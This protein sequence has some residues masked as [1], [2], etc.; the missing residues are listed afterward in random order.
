MEDRVLKGRPLLGRKQSGLTNGPSVKPKEVPVTIGVADM[1]RAKEFYK[2]GIG[3]PVKKAFGNKFVMFGGDDGTSD[4][5]MYKRE[6]LAKDAAVDPAGSGFHG[7]SL[8][9]ALE[10]REAV[11]AL[12]RRAV[13][14]GGQIVKPATEAAR[15]GYFG[16]FADPDRHLWQVTTRN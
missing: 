1:K 12:L 7:F 4:L 2:D 5:G 6:A 15:R 9:H 14:A 3:L 8:T 10:S 16:Y 13:K 11:D